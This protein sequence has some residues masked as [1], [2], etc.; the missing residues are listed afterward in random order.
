VADRPDPDDGGMTNTTSSSFLRRTAAALALGAFATS[1][2]LA[3]SVGT[4]Q[5]VIN[6]PTTATRVASVNAVRITGGTNSLGRSITVTD[7]V[8]VIELFG[9]RQYIP[10]VLVSDTK[11]IT[12]KDGCTQLSPTTVDCGDPSTVVT[13]QI[14]G[15]DGADTIDTRGSSTRSTS[16]SVYRGD[17]VVRT[18]GSDD[19]IYGAEGNDLL[20]G[21]QRPAG[22][23]YDYD[24]LLGGNEGQSVRNTTID[25]CL[26]GSRL[27]D[28]ERLS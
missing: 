7:G 15:T 20:D 21:G 16:I 24:Y 19:T 27:N 5:A 8:R 26:N 4:A 1:A 17:D 18:G 10:A 28:C 3:S 13:V 11:G 6:G 12:A 2:A 9:R 25:T 23:G 14:N 22:Q